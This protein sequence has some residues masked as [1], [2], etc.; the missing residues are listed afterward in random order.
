MGWNLAGGRNDDSRAISSAVPCIP[1]VL[2]A[3]ST[4]AHNGDIGRDS[5]T[6]PPE[7]KRRTKPQARAD[8]TVIVL[9]KGLP[10]RRE[11]ERSR[12]A[13]PGTLSIVFAC[14]AR[15]PRI[16]TV[17]SS[18]P[19]LTGGPYSSYKVSRWQPSQS[20][21]RCQGPQGPPDK[22][23]CI[24]NPPFANPCLQHD[25][26][27]E[28]NKKGPVFRPGLPSRAMPQSFH[29]ARLSHGTGHLRSP[30]RRLRARARLRGT[31]Y[32][33]DDV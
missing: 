30:A 2:A 3:N 32:R 19:S 21:R 8:S 29:S 20:D 22:P 6:L 26:V 17:R 1:Y 18:L 28:P 23:V 24:G 14:L 15:P 12:P 11:R 33:T 25:L 13:Q 7:H 27:T 10:L 5:T 31:A 16:A 4:G 9:E